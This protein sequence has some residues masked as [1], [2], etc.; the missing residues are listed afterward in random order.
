MLNI[1]ND[2]LDVPLRANGKVN[3]RIN[4][5]KLENLDLQSYIVMA[6][7]R[8]YTAI[9][10]IPQSI[11]FDIQTLQIL[12]GV[13]GYV[14][15]K[16]VRNALNGYQL[17]GGVFNHTATIRFLNT[18]QLTTIKQKYLGLDV[19]DQLK[20]ETHIEGEIP[21]LPND[22]KLIIEEYQ[23]QYTQTAPGVIQISSTRPYKYVDNN[24]E[25]THYF[26]IEQVY[27]FEHCRFE[28]S[29]VGETWKLKVGRNFISYESREQII[30]FGLSN[31]ITPLGG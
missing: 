6:D 7:G 12:G 11:G 8:A 17:T 10:K 15:A 29:S 23:E 13:I 16:P 27:T 31:K 22:S 28:N 2:F 3:G 1:K 19:F 26:N 5:E 14:F 21:T 4:S 25:I 30:R 20:L 18:S 9:S 24:E